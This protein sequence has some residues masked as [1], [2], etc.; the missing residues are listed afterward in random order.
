MNFLAAVF[1]DRSPEF[2]FLSRKFLQQQFFE[3]KLFLR[4]NSE[5]HATKATT[6]KIQ[7]RLGVD[8]STAEN[9]QNANGKY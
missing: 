6:S 9:K 4:S 2:I 8:S 7:S 5:L 1:H 3:T